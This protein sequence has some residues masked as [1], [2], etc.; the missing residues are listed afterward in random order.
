VLKP[1]HRYAI[2][3]QVVERRP[4]VVIVV[5]R[6]ARIVEKPWSEAPLDHAMGM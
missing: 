4:G 6:A 1:E 5:P 3:M 2:E